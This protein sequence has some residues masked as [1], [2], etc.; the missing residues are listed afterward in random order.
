MLALDNR[1]SVA[2]ISFGFRSYSVGANV[3]SSVC[4]RTIFANVSSVID[5]TC[6]KIFSS[7][8]VVKAWSSAP[9]G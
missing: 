9:R 8:V 3:S 1:T 5:Y 2:N 7:E 4:T 6:H